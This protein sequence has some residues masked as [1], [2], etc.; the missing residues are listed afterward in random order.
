MVI[1]DELRT[2]NIEVNQLESDTG[3]TRLKF[4]TIVQHG[5]WL[6][7]SI[8]LV[9]QLRTNTLTGVNNNQQLTN[10]LP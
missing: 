9:H 8:K 10:D 1:I 6:T 3:L 2:M 5:K 4:S 7:D